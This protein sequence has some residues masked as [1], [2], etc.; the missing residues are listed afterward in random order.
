MKRLWLVLMIIMGLVSGVV[1]QDNVNLQYGESIVGE[2]TAD[3]SVVPVTFTGS[4]GDVIYV[5]A[6]NNLVPVSITLRSPT[7]GQLAIAESNYLDNIEL[8]TDG[9]Y[10]IEFIRPEWSVDEGE[11]VAHLGL[12]TIETLTAEGENSLIFDG[13]L[14]AA[15]A[16]QII[17]ADMTEGDIVTATLFGANVGM[18]VI[19]PEGDIIAAEGVYNDPM[20]PLFQFP[21]TGTYRIQ[22]IT[23]EP[24][25]TEISLHLY[26]H[27]LIPVTTNV[28][29]IGEINEDLPVVFAFEAQAGKLWDLNAILPE[30]GDKTLAIYQF[31]GRPLWQTQLYRDNGSGPKGQPRIRPFIPDTDDTYYVA[32]WYDDW[33][34]DY[35]TYNYELVV[36]PSTIL[37]L[38]NNS[39][40]I[41]EVTEVSGIAQYVY[42]G[43]AGD[44]IR[45][46][47]RKT[48]EAG[49]MALTIYSTEDEIVT[50]MARNSTIT[51]FDITLPMDGTYEFVVR[52][53]AY[54]TTT[55]LGFEIMVEPQ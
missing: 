28:P 7:G 43:V 50:F 49:D 48:S 31:D 18:D 1:A 45:V 20:I 36:S 40:I 17:E 22:L 34:T 38:P 26:R 9:D 14:S 44:R 55:V 41:G 3:T 10:T 35:A 21:T 15:G 24:E 52:N 37:G 32:L 29:M 8:G 16:I 42:T 2:F 30:T 47:F 27:D 13:E 39:P 46:T 6:L 23:S 53:A 54:D 4:V 5:S 33:N 19:T 51:S 12:Y 11:F 25:G